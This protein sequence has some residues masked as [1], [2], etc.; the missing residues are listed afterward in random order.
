VEEEENEKIKE[1]ETKDEKE[2]QIT[3]LCRDNQ[4]YAR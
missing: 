3:V 4:T 2:E 1:K